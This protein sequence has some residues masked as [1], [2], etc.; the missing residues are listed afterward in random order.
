MEP[1]K[2]RGA[3]GD[4]GQH[5]QRPLRF[6]VFGG[7]LALAF[8]TTL[9]G[10]LKALEAAELGRPRTVLNVVDVTRRRLPALREGRAPGAVRVAFLGDSTSISYP[11]QRTIPD[12]LERALAHGEGPRSPVEIHN[13]AISGV[14]PF[15]YYFLSGEIMAARPDAVIFAFNLDTLSDAWRG[16]NSRPEL[17]GWVGP[18]RLGEALR[19]PLHWIGLT[20]DQLFFYVSLVR[21]GAYEAWRELKIEQARMGRARDAFRQ[22]LGDLC[23]PNPE[24]AFD[25][26]LDAHTLS[27]LCLPGSDNR[28]F[29]RRGQLEHHGDALAGIDPGH[30]VLRV[31]AATLA[32]L[33]AGG[34][35]V[36][37]YVTPANVEH[38]RRLDILDEI[39]L[40][41]TVA[42]VEEVSLAAGA[43]FADLHDLFPDEAFRDASGHLAYEGAIDGPTAVAE[44]LAPL[45]PPVL[46]RSLEARD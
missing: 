37:V 43:D 4:P 9:A 22:R 14:G 5:R 33:Q 42:A 38:M 3:G 26:A 19:L 20:T 23:S 31:F 30:P 45:L 1:G 21:A 41:A 46:A 44:A 25:A 8:A 18:A 36:L 28:R 2:R 39:G 29:S 7:C 6:L 40:A 17:A 16:N 24:P 13:L 34:I 10:F 32:R 12:H 27:L 35:P 11:R 15:E